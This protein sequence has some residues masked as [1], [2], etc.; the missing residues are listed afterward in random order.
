MRRRKRIEGRFDVNFER[1]KRWR[2]YF[3]VDQVCP[4]DDLKEPASRFNK[5]RGIVQGI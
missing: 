2:L 1:P 5:E 3:G 4:Q